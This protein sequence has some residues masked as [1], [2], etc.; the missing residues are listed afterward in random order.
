M[1]A[2]VLLSM[3]VVWVLGPYR[4]DLRD[5]ASIG[6]DSSNYYA[7]GQ[8]LDD[9]HDLYALRSSDRPV[10][11]GTSPSPWAYPLLSPPPIAVLWRVLALIPGD[12]AM[13]LWWL[14]GAVSSLLF[15]YW[16]ILRLHPP[17]LGIAI[18][19]LPSLGITAFS[20]NVN[21]WLIPLCGLVWIADRQGRFASAG[22]GVAAAAILKLTPGL[23]GWWLVGQGH[24]RAVASAIAGFV[25]GL[26]VTIVGAGM[27][28][29]AMYPSVAANA[30]SIGLSPL[31]SVSVVSSLGLAAG[32][33]TLSPYVIAV[34]A[35]ALAYG[36]R[37]RPD[38]SFVFCAIGVALGTPAVRFETLA[39]L[40]LALV[41]WAYQGASR[42][43]G[44]REASEAS[45]TE[46]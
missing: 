22:L 8:R 29:L 15:G 12:I 23:Y 27:S 33:A 34:A 7:A 25:I 36:F 6:S 9:G 19:L 20:G 43:A 26:V 28:S 18:L 3:S 14:G 44:P 1:A 38:L 24:R 13:Y 41:P 42:L 4:P 21:A 31:S 2:V 10:A 30:T 40:L 5:P 32:A 45:F 46:A 39:W 35:A 11:N 17:Q 16:L 37:R